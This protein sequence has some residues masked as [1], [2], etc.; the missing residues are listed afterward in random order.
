MTSEESLKLV[1]DSINHLENE[2]CAYQEELLGTRNYVKRL[3]VLG[4]V[5]V[6]YIVCTLFY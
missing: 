5:L 1:L 6:K 4:I 2:T 3:E